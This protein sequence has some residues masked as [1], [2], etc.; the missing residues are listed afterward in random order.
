MNKKS[1]D[2]VSVVAFYLPQFHPIPEN[3]EWWGKGFTEW[4]N[5][6]KAKPLYRNHYQP[7]VP[8][9]LGYYDLR[10]PETRQAQA[11]MAKEYGIKAFCYWHYWFGN[12][13]RLLDRP[14]KEVLESGKPDF[15][16]CLG[17]A[18]HSGEKKTWSSD[19]EDKLLISQ[20][21][22]GDEDYIQ[23]FYSILEAFKDK[24]Y[25][26]VDN[27]LLFL[28][29]S[30]EEIPDSKRF[31]SLW[32]KLAKDNGLDDIHFVAYSTATKHVN[33]FVEYGYDTVV[34]EILQESFFQ[35]SFITK[36]YY[37]LLRLLFSIP[38]I[39]DYNSYAKYYLETYFVS[40]KVVPCIV[41][42]FDHSPRSK[43]RG[44]I[45]RDSSPQNFG[46]LLSKI[47]E[48]IYKSNP[49]YKLLFIKSW[50]EWGEGNHLEPDLKYGKRHLESLKKSLNDKSMFT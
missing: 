6:G 47:L 22:P 49:E 43:G 24:R 25:F 2:G 17:W 18:N 26:H 32:K 44:L 39:L 37:R 50:N 23:H 45:L 16:F 12:G 3:D 46:M 48:R 13:K 38:K 7:H 36:S 8:A 29:W 14:F 21:Y 4:T 35:R 42:N 15:P 41:P 10:V 9:D 5:V 11:D 19:N 40:P 33:R 27:K 34:L 20:E 1:E 31:I 28:V 30:P